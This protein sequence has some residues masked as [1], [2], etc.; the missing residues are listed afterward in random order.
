MY[1][2]ILLTKTVIE[3]P[4]LFPESADNVLMFIGAKDYI[5]FDERVEDVRLSLINLDNHNKWVKGGMLDEGAIDNIKPTPEQIECM[6]VNTLNAAYHNPKMYG[7]YIQCR[8]EDSDSL[9]ESADKV[10]AYLAAQNGVQSQTGEYFYL[11]EENGDFS[12]RDKNA[13][14]SNLTIDGES[15]F[16]EGMRATATLAAHFAVASRLLCAPAEREFSNAFF[17]PN[18]PE[19]IRSMLLISNG[20]TRTLNYDFKTASIDGVM[21]FEFS[22]AEE[23]YSRIVKFPTALEENRFSQSDI[24]VENLQGDVLYNGALT[25]ASFSEHIMG[26]LLNDAVNRLGRE[27]VE[28]SL[29]NHLD[30]VALSAD[31]ALSRGDFIKDYV[32]SI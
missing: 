5:C 21:Q 22:G 25:V 23:P 9:F 32:P 6:Q 18:I 10:A 15:E 29:K 13:F 2:P 11:R 1:D 24:K 28:Q 20:D 12:F 7:L 31:G 19:T 30:I 4:F 14:R 8:R 26:P 3:D 27:R 17:F 16:A